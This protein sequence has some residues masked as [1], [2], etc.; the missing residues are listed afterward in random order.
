MNSMPTIKTYVLISFHQPP[1]TPLSTPAIIKRNNS[2][3][4]L[5]QFAAE[6]VAC[7]RLVAQKEED[8]NT[9]WGQDRILGLSPPGQ[10]A[11]AKRR[12]NLQ[13]GGVMI[14]LARDGRS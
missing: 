5:C 3:K 13:V 4:D 14:P 8:E 9:G 12:A 7:N 6:A 11:L 2:A 10:S 1:T